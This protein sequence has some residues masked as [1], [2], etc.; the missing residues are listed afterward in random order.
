MIEMY[1][2]LNQHL[3]AKYNEKLQKI[4][5]IDQDVKKLEHL[6]TAGGNIK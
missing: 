4:S 6:Y 1:D 3:K 2:I 5:S